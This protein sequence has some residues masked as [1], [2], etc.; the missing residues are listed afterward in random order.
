MLSIKKRPDARYEVIDI[1]GHSHSMIAVIDGL[2]PAACV[3]RFLKG[4][5]LQPEEYQLAVNTM[6]EIDDMEGG[7][8]DAG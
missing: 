3:L 1:G 4:S 2:K 6:E 5:H 7:G 8:N